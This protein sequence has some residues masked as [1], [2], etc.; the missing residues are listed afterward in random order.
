MCNKASTSEID[1][2]LDSLD[3]HLR[4]N[5][6]L[7]RKPKYWHK[8]YSTPALLIQAKFNATLPCSI[9]SPRHPLVSGL[10]NQ[11]VSPS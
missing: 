3:L 4:T 5:Y 2:L 7:K 11:Q 1:A 8:T 10:C 9:A 6:V